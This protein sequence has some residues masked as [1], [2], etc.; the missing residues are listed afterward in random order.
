MQPNETKAVIERDITNLIN[1]IITLSKSSDKKPIDIITEDSL[2]IRSII[3]S[4]NALKPSDPEWKEIIRFI[5]GI[6]PDF[7]NYITKLSSGSTLNDRQ[8]HIISLLRIGVQNNAIARILGIDPSTVTYN[9]KKICKILF[10]DKIS[11]DQ[12]GRVLRAI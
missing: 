8:I 9:R 3:K 6:S 10:R 12:L 2:A 4:G 1:S 5:I 11:I 7:F